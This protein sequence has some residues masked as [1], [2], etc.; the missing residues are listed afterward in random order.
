MKLIT[1][2]EQSHGAYF[3]TIAK[4]TCRK[5]DGLQKIIPTFL[6]DCDQP[7]F[8]DRMAPNGIV[9]YY[10]A[11]NGNEIS[12]YLYKGYDMQLIVLAFI[13]LDGVAGFLIDTR[14]GEIEDTHSR[15]FNGTPSCLDTHDLVKILESLPFKLVE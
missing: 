4:A 15:N 13:G 10:K 8:I 6:T 7:W 12:V 1:S 14:K 5:F 11:P 3:N 9:R 2:I